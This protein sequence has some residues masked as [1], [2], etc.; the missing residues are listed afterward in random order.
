MKDKCTRK[1]FLYSK[2]STFIIINGIQKVTKRSIIEI[3]HPSQEQTLGRTPIQGQT[4]GQ[5]QG[6][7]ASRANTSPDPKNQDRSNSSGIREVPSTSSGTTVTVVTDAMSLA[8]VTDPIAL[9]R[10]TDALANE[11]SN[12]PFVTSGIVSDHDFDGSGLRWPR[13]IRD[14]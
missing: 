7:S 1:A 4:Q 13:P 14:T 2:E 11:E 10:V 5:R 9:A 8:M 6:R 3:E 12:Q